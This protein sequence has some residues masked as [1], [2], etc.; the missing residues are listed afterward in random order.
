M[1]VRPYSFTIRSERVAALGGQELAYADLDASGTFDAHQDTTVF[2]NDKNG[3]GLARYAE[4]RQ[5]LTDLGGTAT[6]QQLAEHTG[7]QETRLEPA[8]SERPLA[9]GR[10]T[11]Q[12][13]GIR[14]DFEELHSVPVIAPRDGNVATLDVNRDGESEPLHDSLLML[15]TSDGRNNY[16][17]MVSLDELTKAVEAA[18]GSLGEGQLAC[19]SDF[20][21]IRSTSLEESPPQYDTMG[22]QRT[23]RTDDSGKLWLDYGA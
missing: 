15:H 20:P 5:A 11:L 4:L 8:K 12:P 6:G 22:L 14:A 13:D 21:G 2:W 9:N 18:G 19:L 7:R 17:S 3:G 10:F 1:E 23:L 16:T